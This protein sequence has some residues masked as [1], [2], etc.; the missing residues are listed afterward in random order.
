[1]KLLLALALAIAG[2]TAALAQY[3]GF[4]ST[5]GL[6]GTGWRAP[7]VSAVEI[8]SHFDPGTIRLTPAE[9]V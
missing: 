5:G 6:N 8:A 4:G 1:M 9:E 3:G 7:M 2:A